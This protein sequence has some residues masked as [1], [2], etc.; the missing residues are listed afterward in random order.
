MRPSPHIPAGGA[1]GFAGN[2]R[3]RPQARRD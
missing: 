3:R 2:V 1:F